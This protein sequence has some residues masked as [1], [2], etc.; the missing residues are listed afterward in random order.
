[1][2]S[3]LLAAMISLI[4]ASAA[5]AQSGSVSGTVLDQSGAVV[6]GA[7]VVLSGAGEVHSSVSGPNGTYAFSNLADGTYRLTVSLAGFAPSTG[8]EIVV[9]GGPV[10]VAAITLQTAT[11]GETVIVSASKLEDSLADAPATM[12]V[13]TAT[14]I[15]TSSA[16]NFGDLLRAVPG[17]NTIQMSARDVNVTSRQ[18]T[19]TLSNTEL[20]LLDGRSIYQDFFG[21]VLWDFIPSQ[22][23][24]IKQIEVVRG[25]A[26][27]VWGANALNGVVM[28]SG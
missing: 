28:P 21:F 14:T 13:V 17:V 10:E 18:A 24:D 22:V 16:Q 5:E 4:T 26:S 19:S 23:S 11:L 9:G 2:H 25:P 3:L 27:V 1:M 8:T 15:A 12:S 7:T 20:V 6:P